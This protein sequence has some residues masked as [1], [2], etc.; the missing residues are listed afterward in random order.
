MN[1]LTR[2]I[3]ASIALLTAVIASAAPFCVVTGAGKQCFYSDE[4]S[5]ERAAASAGG[6]CVV[7]SAEVKAPATGAPFCV[8]T[9]AGA[10]CSYYN[11][12]ACENA[13]KS[14]RGR[15]VAR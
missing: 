15:C 7:N 1:S 8:V 12:Q 2:A 3:L 6:A 10:Q 5:C 13:A 11:F 4:P 14:L 9:S